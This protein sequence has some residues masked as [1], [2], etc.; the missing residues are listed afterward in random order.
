MHSCPYRCSRSGTGILSAH[1]PARC[2]LFYSM[3]DYEYF[4]K[5]RRMLRKKYTRILILSFIFI[6]FADIFFT[7]ISLLE[8]GLF[9]GWPAKKETVD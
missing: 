2:S 4:R 6:L 5:K 1:S 7:I 9:R 3:T 8:G